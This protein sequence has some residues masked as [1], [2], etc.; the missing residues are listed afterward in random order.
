MDDWSCLLTFCLVA[1]VHAL[2]F[3][4]LHFIVCSSFHV[5]NFL[6]VSTKYV[7]IH[8]LQ[9]YPIWCRI[10]DPVLFYLLGEQVFASIFYVFIGVLM[11][12]L[13]VLCTFSAIHLTYGSVNMIV[14][15][16]SFQ[17]CSL[18]SIFLFERKDCRRKRSKLVC[19]KWLIT[20]LYIPYMYVTIED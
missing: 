8:N 12:F 20:I 4:F 16:L 14:Y 1:R 6:P 10:S 5:L 9:E 13:T 3:S 7:L 2:D 19:L 17:S 18:N 11:C 15:R